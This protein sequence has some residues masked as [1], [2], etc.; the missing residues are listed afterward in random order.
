MNYCKWCDIAH[1]ERS[2]PLCY[3][4]EE[5]KSLAKQIGELEQGLADGKER[6]Q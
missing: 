3:A 2:C 6:T 4:R 1:E 5:I